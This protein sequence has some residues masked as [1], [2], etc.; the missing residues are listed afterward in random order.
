MTVRSFPSW[1]K[2]R[3]STLDRYVFHQLLIALLA[4][5]GGLAA[6]IWLMQSL[7]FV[8]LVVDRGLSLRVFI[9]LTSLLI[10]SF[11]AVVLPITT[12]V[13]SLFIY[14]RL[15]GD[16]E[17]TVMRAAGLSPLALARPGLTCALMATL[18]GF[19]LNLWVV[20]VSYHHFRQFEFQIR[21]KMAA[22]ML[23]EGV[24][25]KVSDVMT[26]YIRE[27]SHDGTLH[28]IVVEDDRQPNSRATIL[29][30]RGTMMIVND[31]PRVILYDGSRQVID[32]KT[33]RL[34]MLVFQQ[35]SMDLSST[36]QEDSRFRDAAEMSL[37][38]LLNPNPKEVAP[39]D[40]G[41]FKVEGWRRLT[42]PL[43]C[44]SFAMVGL[45]AVLRGVFS[46][47]GNI[48]RPLAAV[49]S[50]VGLLAFNLLLQ[51]LASRNMALIPLIPLVA[52]L[53]GLACAAILFVPELRL[54]SSSRTV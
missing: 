23:Q 40:T 20:P 1:L 32:H 42:S 39:R 47:H 16:R 48:K 54:R 27:R 52:L 36:H 15:A 25:T 49:L 38:E 30:N 11:V 51:N 31:T 43:T 53:P 8:S 35:D 37:H 4:T 17:L 7:R 26:V 13:V 22:F 24:F 2:A 21:N 41:K 50:V 3:V 28:G 9:E 34:D 18:I 10:P 12:F 29:A 6:L 5:T 19:L 45:F 14:Q 46:R 44:F 33:G